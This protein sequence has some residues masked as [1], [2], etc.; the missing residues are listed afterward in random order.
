MFGAGASFGSGEVD[1]YPP[2][3]GNKLY[4]E[5]KISFTESWGTLE[6]GDDK[7]FDINFEEGMQSMFDKHTIV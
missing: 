7:Q 3:L 4:E 6:A 2:P 1:P 5:L